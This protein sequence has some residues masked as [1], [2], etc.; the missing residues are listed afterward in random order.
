[1]TDGV[2]FV[3][4]RVITQPGCA[5]RFIDAYLAQYAP[6]ARAR[7]MALRDV[8]VSPPVWFEDQSNTVTITWSLPSAQAWWEMTWMGRPDPTLGQWW[9]DIADLVQERSRTAAAAAADVDRLCDV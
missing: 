4:D 6:G 9:D 2:V 1:M 8:L 3:I 5:K 7:G